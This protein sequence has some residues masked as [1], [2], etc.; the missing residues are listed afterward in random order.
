MAQQVAGERP[1]VSV[2][3]LLPGSRSGSRRSSPYGLL[4]NRGEE[5]IVGGIGSAVLLFGMCGIT[6]GRGSFAALGIDALDRRDARKQSFP[7]AADYRYQQPGNGIRI[8]RG[9]VGRGFSCDAAAI[10]RFPGG[11]GEMFSERLAAFVIEL[12]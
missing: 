11:P 6:A 2:R 12:G 9:H 5:N 4:T 10:V 7:A 3:N 1:L 8:G